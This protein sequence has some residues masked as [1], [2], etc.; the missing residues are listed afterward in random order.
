MNEMGLFSD[1]GLEDEA[2][3]EAEE[4]EYAEKYHARGWEF[5]WF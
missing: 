4:K 2:A 1:T 3:I 5:D